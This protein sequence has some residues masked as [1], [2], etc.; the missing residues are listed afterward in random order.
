MTMMHPLDVVRMPYWAP[1]GNVSPHLPS[2][3]G[4]DSPSGSGVIDWQLKSGLSCQRMLECTYAIPLIQN[5]YAS[6]T[7]K[8]MQRPIVFLP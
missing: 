2:W 4:S 6:K 8:T 7:G 1:H 5:V 3:T